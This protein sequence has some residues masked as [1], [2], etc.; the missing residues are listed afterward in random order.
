MSMSAARCP[1]PI[2]HPAKEQEGGP[3]KEKPLSRPSLD[4]RQILLSHLS[5]KKMVAGPPR[6]MADSTFDIRHLYAQVDDKAS[7][8]NSRATLPSNQ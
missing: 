3:K 8:Y 4:L 2:A 7:E 1:S 6:R 5:P